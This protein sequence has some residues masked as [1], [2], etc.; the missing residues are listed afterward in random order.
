ME[1]PYA[2]EPLLRELGLE[3]QSDFLRVELG[4]TKHRQE[5][6]SATLKEVEHCLSC[7]ALLDRCCSRQVCRLANKQ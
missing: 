1:D 7:W 6:N 3:F 2:L 5:G 4:E